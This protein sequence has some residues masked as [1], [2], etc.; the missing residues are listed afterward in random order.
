MKAK[1]IKVWDDLRFGCIPFI[2]LE[3]DQNDKLLLEN[4]FKEKY[5]F[6]VQAINHRVGAAGGYSFDPYRDE[7]VRK[8]SNKINTTEADVLGFYL[9][10]VDDIYNI[11]NELFTENFWGVVRTD[12]YSEERESDSEYEINSETCYKV[13]IESEPIIIEEQIND[14]EDIL[15]KG[16]VFN[17]IDYKNLFEKILKEYEEEKTYNNARGITSNTPIRSER[18]SIDLIDKKT[19]ERITSEESNKESIIAKYLWLPQ[20][21]LPEELWSEVKDKNEDYSIKRIYKFDKN[22][23]L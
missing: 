2:V 9:S 8:I 20:D 23:E 7:R 19:L 1:V 21:V 11:P 4:G 13:L 18:I 3:V 17:S 14:I 10:N 22:I 16:T 15:N 5:R 12:G 6:I